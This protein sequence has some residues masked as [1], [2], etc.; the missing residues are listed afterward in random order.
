MCCLREIDYDVLASSHIVCSGKPS[1]ESKRYT[2]C[3]IVLGAA[4]NRNMNKTTQH[5]I[6]HKD[7]ESLR[8]HGI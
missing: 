6:T 8:N 4:R 5:N 7:M 3:A 2:P 1:K